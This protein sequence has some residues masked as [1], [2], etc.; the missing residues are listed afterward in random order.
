MKRERPQWAAEAV[1]QMYQYGIHNGD[2]A[3]ETGYNTRYISSILSGARQSE[4]VQVAI[5]AALNRMIPKD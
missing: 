1:H 4:R 5:L 3:K 2:L